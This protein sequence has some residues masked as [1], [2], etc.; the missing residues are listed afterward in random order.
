MQ[1]LFPFVGWTGHLH[2]PGKIRMHARILPSLKSQ[3]WHCRSMLCTHVGGAHCPV[4]PYFVL[5]LHVGSSAMTPNVMLQYT[6]DST[7]GRS[8]GQSRWRSSAQIIWSVG[9]WLASIIVLLGI[10]SV[11]AGHCHWHWQSE[12]LPKLSPA[13]IDVV[14]NKKQGGRR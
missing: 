2:E 7:L 13:W 14:F 11:P 3:W 10:G 8:E 6:W 4:G 12:S 9:R 5:L 1:T